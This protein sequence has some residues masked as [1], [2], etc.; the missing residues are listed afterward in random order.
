M[1]PQL[2]LDVIIEDLRI[3][4]STQATI[5]NILEGRV[6]FVGMQEEE[7]LFPSFQDI[8]LIFRVT[9]NPGLEMKNN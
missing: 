1:F 2:S 5:E 6:G 8:F 9:M 7:V 3:S 4:G